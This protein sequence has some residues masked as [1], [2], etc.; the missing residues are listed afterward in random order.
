MLDVEVIE[1]ADAARSA[2]DPTRARLLR[3]LSTPQS[4]AMLGAKLGIPRQKLN[5]HLRQLE[6]HGLV[7]LHDTRAHGGLTERVLAATAAA[8]FVDPALG[9]GEPLARDD[10]LSARYLIAVAARAVREVGRLARRGPVATLTIDT[11]IGFATPADRAAFADELAAAVTQLAANYHHDGGRMHRLVV[12]A[13]PLPEED[14][15]A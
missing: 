13:H 4:A 9:G 15:A 8:F 2:L 7:E 11:E 3:E 1:S 5:Y 12:A 6:A 14:P 10:R